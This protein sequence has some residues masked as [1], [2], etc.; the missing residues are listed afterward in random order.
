[1]MRLIHLLPHLFKKKCARACNR[2]MGEVIER[3]SLNHFDS[4]KIH[5]NNEGGHEL[6]FFF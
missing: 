4:L 1:V 6:K 2:F 5:L 3:R